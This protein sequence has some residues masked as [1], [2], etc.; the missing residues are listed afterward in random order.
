MAVSE[1]SICN[2]ALARVAQGPIVNINDGDRLA[3]LCK[4]HYG[5]K[6]DALLRDYR[7]KF[8]L[9][10]AALPASATPPAFGYANAYVL[11]VDCL[12]VLSINDI[13]PEREPDLAEQWDRE[14]DT[15]VTDLGAPLKIRYTARVTDPTRF[16]ASFV[17]ALT[18][19]LALY[20]APSIKEL[21]ANLTATMRQEFEFIVSRARHTSAI[22]G[23]P[24][25]R[26]R[27]SSS[28]VYGR[29]RRA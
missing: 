22:E 26:Y 21:D 2:Q 10:R 1:T 27:L 28:W 12:R 6:R 3:R 9:R 14:G 5:P 7:W 23:R 24:V 4:L 11:P 19:Y 25:R 29:R 8:A 16:D 15:I 18:A 20:L 13:D 17:D